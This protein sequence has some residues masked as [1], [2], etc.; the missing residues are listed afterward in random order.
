MSF[1]KIV[2]QTPVKHGNE[3]ALVVST[4]QVGFRAYSTTVFDDTPDRRLEG[5]KIGD[6]TI[7]TTVE[8]ANTR[9]EAMDQHR[10]ALYS[11]RTETPRAPQS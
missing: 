8:Q 9:E 11:A 3:W 10:E 5:W 1:P 7:E 6:R 2:R 4:V